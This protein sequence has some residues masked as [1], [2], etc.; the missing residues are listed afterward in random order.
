MAKQ[1]S[2]LSFIY[3]P[4]SFQTEGVEGTRG[5]LQGAVLNKP[6]QTSAS[7][8]RWHLD[9]SQQVEAPNDELS[10]IHPASQALGSNMAIH[11]AKTAPSFPLLPLTLPSVQIWVS[12]NTL[13]ISD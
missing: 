9:C 10:D 2:H 11:L 1:E 5:L 13:Y 6:I 7:P 4:Q 12:M 3:T 8:W